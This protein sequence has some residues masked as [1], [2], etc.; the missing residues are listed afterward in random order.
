LFGSTVTTLSFEGNS[1]KLLERR[2]NE[3][4]VWSTLIL[5][6]QQMSQGQVHLPQVLGE[7]L[8]EFFE[9]TG[10]SKRRIVSCVT[11]QR[12]LHRVLTLPK[13]K[14]KF[15]EETIKR[16]A[17]Q[18]FAIPVEETDLSWRLIDQNEDSIR[19]YML[20]I[21]QIL[22]D[23]QL[24]ALKSARIRPRAMDAKPLALIRAA[25][26]RQCI[27][28]DF[29]SYSMTV[30]IV[31]ESIP[32]I[33]RTVP[34]EADNLTDEA[35]LELLIQELGRTT[36]FYNESN[37][38]D[39]IPEDT[40]LITSGGMFADQQTEQRLNDRISY[41]AS[42]PEPPFSLPDDLPVNQYAVN[43]GLALKKI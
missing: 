12:S 20:A 32:M 25:N 33:V 7:R 15:I 40:P 43:L 29:E 18:E 5:P 35:K 39:R 11:G 13:V 31:R 24:E 6:E 17:K 36:K 8:S 2:R 19:V 1:V 3:V 4:S 21:P 26:Q 10:A 27:I 9:E 41:P 22:I 14:K 30:I 37:K 23:R 38:E 34:L 28:A 42:K 16:K